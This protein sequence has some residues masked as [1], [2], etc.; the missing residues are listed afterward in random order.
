MLSGE[1]SGTVESGTVESRTVESGTVESIVPF[2]TVIWSLAMQRALS[3]MKNRWC[4]V[5][6][7]NNGCE[8]DN[9]IS[10]APLHSIF[11]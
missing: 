6:R 2:A 7:S 10:M 9:S 8:E 3:S 1:S 4:C 11:A 5:M